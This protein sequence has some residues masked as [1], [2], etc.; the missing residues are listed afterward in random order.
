MFSG[1]AAYFFCKNARIKGAVL[2]GEFKNPLK[3]K[4]RI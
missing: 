2:N 1:D 4:H 3:R